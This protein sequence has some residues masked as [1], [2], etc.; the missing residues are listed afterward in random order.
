MQ[1]SVTRTGGT[2]YNLDANVTVTY[3]D[4]THDIDNGTV[5]MY[6]YIHVFFWMRV[7][8]YEYKAFLYSHFTISDFLTSVHVS[9]LYDIYELNA[10]DIKAKMVLSECP[11]HF[12]LPKVTFCH[13]CSLFS[14]SWRSFVL[15]HVMN[16]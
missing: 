5:N 2:D 13:Y 4:G 15:F 1:L 16:K 7:L 3:D 9:S 10:N 6:L 11:T 14:Y 12:Q 8:C